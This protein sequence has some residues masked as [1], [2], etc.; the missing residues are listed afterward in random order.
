[1]AQKEEGARGKLLARP[2]GGEGL[3]RREVVALP[4][5]RP[6]TAPPAP[7]PQGN[8]CQP[9]APERDYPNWGAMPSSSPHMGAPA[10]L[11]TPFST[12]HRDSH[13]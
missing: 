7:A 12:P 1:M 2:P 4:D 6:V 5:T 11:L 13:S 9:R 8:H 3:A 10:P